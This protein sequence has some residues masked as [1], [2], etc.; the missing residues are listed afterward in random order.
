MNT[1]ATPWRILTEITKEYHTFHTWA[2]R[3]VPKLNF[4]SRDD[5]TEDA[6]TD[7]ID[8]WLPERCR[9]ADVLV[10]RI[11]QINVA[12]Q[13]YWLYFKLQKKK[14]TNMSVVNIKINYI[15]WA[16]STET[17]I[18]TQISGSHF[19]FKLN[20]YLDFCRALLRCSHNFRCSSKQAV[21]CFA[22]K[23]SLPL[24][25]PASSNRAK[26]IYSRIFGKKKQQN[27]EPAHCH[28]FCLQADPAQCQ[29]K[30]RLW[31]QCDQE[32][33]MFHICHQK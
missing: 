21:W 13:F 14:L 7:D 33:A 20:E 2:A 31:I 1:G 15:K 5:V 4:E 24:K 23:I 8:S 3:G 11:F 22:C 19:L 28:H 27:F 18:S 17:Q 32:S 26:F 12:S 9:K 25:L 29:P 6:P 30:H 10:C 16:I